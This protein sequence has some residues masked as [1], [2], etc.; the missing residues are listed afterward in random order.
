MD[1][2]QGNARGRWSRKNEAL[3][4]NHGTG[5]E[6]AVCWQYGVEAEPRT[7]PNQMGAVFV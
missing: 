4:E 6:K 2:I 5:V 1:Y 3:A 7:R